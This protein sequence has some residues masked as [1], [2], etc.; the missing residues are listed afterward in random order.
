M[1]V[2]LNSQAKDVITSAG[3]RR[4]YGCWGALA[5]GFSFPGRGQAGHAL[6]VLVLQASVDLPYKSDFRLT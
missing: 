2:S 5:A 6:G 3:H 1:E 4:R